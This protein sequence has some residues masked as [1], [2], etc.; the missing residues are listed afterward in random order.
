MV[1]LIALYNLYFHSFLT[2][3]PEERPA[4]HSVSTLL[5]EAYHREINQSAEQ[6]KYLIGD[7]RE[8]MAGFESRGITKKLAEFEGN[9]N[10]MQHFVLNYM[11][12]FEMILL[13]VRST[14]QQDR[15]LHMESLESLTNISSR[16]IIKTMPACSLCT[17][18]QCRKLKDNIQTSGQNS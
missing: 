18:Q 16:M 12:Q 6:K 11:K 4:L 9:A 5:G 3:D 1:T 7:I 8:V 2:S 15:Q 10:K 13:F 17:L 14:R